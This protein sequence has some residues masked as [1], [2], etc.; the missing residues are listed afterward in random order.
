MI[1]R[2][3]DG[4]SSSSTARIGLT[5]A[6]SRDDS[7]I[8]PTTNPVDSFGPSGTSTRTPKRTESRRFSGIEYVNVPWTAT[9]SAISANGEIPCGTLPSVDQRRDDDRARHRDIR[10]DLGDRHAHARL[11]RVAHLV[12]VAVLALARD[13]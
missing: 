4:S 10:H 9:G 6:A 11:V 8:R 2:V 3:S 13:L 1:S 7:S 5:F 12:R